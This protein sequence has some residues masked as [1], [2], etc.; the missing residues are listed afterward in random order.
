MKLRWVA[1]LFIAFLVVSSSQTNANQQ[2]M[3][4]LA[5]QYAVAVGS[6][7]FLD[8]VTQKL[9]E[10]CGEAPT[11]SAKELNEVDYLLRKKTN[12]SYLEYIELWILVRT[13]QHFLKRPMNNY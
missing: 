4:D 8:Q 5:E 2:P 13:R 12:V 3:I 1:R 11:L 6:I 9:S 7:N 10:H